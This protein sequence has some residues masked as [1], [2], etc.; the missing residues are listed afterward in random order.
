[1]LLIGQGYPG[2]TLL[3][4]YL[5]LISQVNSSMVNTELTEIQA[6]NSVFQLTWT[7]NN[8][9]TNHCRYCPEMLHNGKNHHYEWQ[10]AERF[11][12]ELMARCPHIQVSIA[13][14]EPTVSPW[15]KDLVNLFQSQGHRVGI[16]SNGVRNAAYWQD[17]R[18]DYLCLSY[19]AAYE[20]Y[21]W[22]GR[23]IQT[24]KT[25]GRVTARIMMDPDRWDQCMKVY[26]LLQLSALGVEAVRIL[27]WG[28]RSQKVTYSPEQL[29]W[30]NS[31]RPKPGTPLPPSER[32]E[33]SAT[34][35]YFAGHTAR[36]TGP[37]ANELISQNLHY[38]TGWQCDIGLNSL[39]VQY[40]GSYRRGNCSQGGYIGWIKDPI[41]KWP[42]TSVICEIPQC[43]CTTDITIS[44]R[45]IPI[46]QI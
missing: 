37:W 33:Y 22:I 14:G 46:R 1:M 24:Q 2:K 20:Q 30:L 5:A 21:D 40:D 23:A 15:L 28:G 6:D 11:A 41:L 19:H 45:L 32:A 44:K 12:R 31:S 42:A 35:R 13:G 3:I 8:I 9:C 34:A 26:N 18:P 10:H 36:A 38:F 29:E 43:H 7:I 16:T 39:F 25:V 27:D 4:L 17:C